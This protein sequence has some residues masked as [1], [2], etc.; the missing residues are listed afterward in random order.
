MQILNAHRTLALTLA[1]TALAPVAMAQAKPTDA[2]PTCLP[3]VFMEIMGNNP[4][5][6]PVK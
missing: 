1:A 3:W 6:L 2:P 4:L 5:F